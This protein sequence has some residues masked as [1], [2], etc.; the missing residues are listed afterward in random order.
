MRMGGKPP[1]RVPGICAVLPSYKK[2][3]KSLYTLY[4]MPGFFIALVVIGEK[5]MQDAEL[6]LPTCSDYIQAV[7][8][9]TQTGQG[10]KWLMI[11]VKDADT[12]RDAERL[13]A[14]RVPAK[15]R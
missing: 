13:M 11:A 9:G 6:M 7:F 4:P 8:A 10:Q 14:L 5:E 12:L 2:G 3:G 1:A 15:R